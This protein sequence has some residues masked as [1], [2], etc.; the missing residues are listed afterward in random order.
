MCFKEYLTSRH[1]WL[2]LSQDD[3]FDFLQS[4]FPKLT[5]DGSLIGKDEFGTVR[6]FTVS[7]VSVLAFG[8]F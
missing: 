6:M 7:M 2:K 5:K 1:A 3:F 8:L 4:I